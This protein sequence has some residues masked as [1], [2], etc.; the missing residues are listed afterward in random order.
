MGTRDIGKDHMTDHK[1]VRSVFYRVKIT[2]FRFIG[3]FYKNAN[4]FAILLY[5]KQ[6]FW[7]SL[8]NK[9]MVVNWL[10]MHYFANQFLFV[11]PHQHVMDSSCEI[12]I[13][14]KSDKAFVIPLWTPAFWLWLYANYLICH[15]SIII[16]RCTILLHVIPV[17]DVF[18][19]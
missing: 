15:P 19:F 17:I 13:L 16:A 14:E 1:P 10:Y 3:Q 12:T 6:L 4:S 2:H 11:D 5:I 7:I 8:K 18:H 9:T